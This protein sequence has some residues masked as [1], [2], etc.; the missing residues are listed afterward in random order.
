MKV[1]YSS[2]FKNNA[3]CVIDAV[4]K[5]YGSATGYKEAVWGKPLSEPQVLSIVERYLK[6]N[7]VNDVKYFFGKSLVTTMSGGGLSL[8]AKPNYYRDVRLISLLDHEIGTHHMRAVNHG[9]LSNNS[10]S[11]IKK[12]RIGW[13][14]ATEEGLACLG[15]HIH[16]KCNLLYI[17]A[18][19]Y[20]SVCVGQECS[21]WDTFKSCWKYV[22]DFD[23]C[24]VTT[25][26]VKRGLTD[27]SRP[28]AF[29]KDQATFDGCM[30]ILENRNSIDFPS[31]YAGKVSLETYYLSKDVLL[32]ASQS[33]DYTCPP[34]IR[35]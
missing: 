26:R 3:K 8:V 7:N 9:N 12:V 25:L 21:F 27:T 22:S 28:G 20:Y 4:I 32:E 30:R 17:P 5:Q 15:N 19:L 10:L 24:W 14:L 33:N 35:G 11:N 13:Q 34:H 2:R 29:C 31:L 6:E 18:L 1:V 16:Y 23:D